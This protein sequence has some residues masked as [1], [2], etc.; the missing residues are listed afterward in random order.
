MLAMAHGPSRRRHLRASAG[1][2][3]MTG[4]LFE[5][6][7]DFAA[8]VAD[9]PADP[10]ALWPGAEVAPV[11]QG[12][13]G[14]ADYVGDFGDGEQF[15]VGVRG[16]GRC[17]PVRDGAHVNLLLLVAPVV[18]TADGVRFFSKGPVRGSQWPT[19]QRSPFQAPYR[20]ARS[21]GVDL[22]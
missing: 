7:E 5:P 15:V 14:D 11:A 3:W 6:L 17:G 19:V 8:P 2:L 21:V 13:D 4:L 18:F 9:G 16:L 20:A 10:K 1:A 12:G 22:R